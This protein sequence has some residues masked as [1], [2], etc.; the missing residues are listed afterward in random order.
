RPLE[1]DGL[2]VDEY[3]PLVRVVEAEEDVHQ[4]GLAGA[5]LAEGRMHLPGLEREVDAVVRGDV[6]EAL[7][8]APQLESHP[9]PPSSWRPRRRLWASQARGACRGPRSTPPV[10]NPD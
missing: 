4:G 6:P 2:A 8:D 10:W 3:P 1:A 5:V 9:R 7:G